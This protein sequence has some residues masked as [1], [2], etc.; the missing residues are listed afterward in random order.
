MYQ[1]HPRRLA[2]D[3]AMYDAVDINKAAAFYT[4]RFASREDMTAIFVGNIDTAELKVLTETY[5]APL[6]NDAA[7]VSWRDVGASRAPGVNVHTFTA[8][9]EDKARVELTFHGPF[10]KNR[11]NDFIRSQL[12][13]AHGRHPRLAKRPMRHH[14]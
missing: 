7:S 2:W 5:L 6:T 12:V 14:S 10:S 1:N 13:Q 4:S 8:G 3:E 9:K 11:A